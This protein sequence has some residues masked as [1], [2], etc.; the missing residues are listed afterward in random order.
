MCAAA[1]CRESLSLKCQR[2]GLRSTTAS[3]ILKSCPRSVS[4]NIFR[5]RMTSRKN[6]ELF[7][8]LIL[9]PVYF[10]L[11]TYRSFHG[12]FGNDDIYTLAW[13][14]LQSP[15]FFLKDTLNFE[16]LNTE[17]LYRPFGALA[18]NILYGIFGLNFFAFHL[19][20]NGIHLFNVFCLYRLIQKLV[21]GRYCALLGAFIFSFHIANLHIYWFVYLGDL[22]CASLLLL[23]L[24]LYI[25]S[26]GTFNLKYFLAFCFFIFALRSK[27]IAF[28]F[29]L[30]LT[31]YEILVRRKISEWKTSLKQVAIT[32]WPFYAI[33]ILAIFMKLS[34]YLHVER[35]HPYAITLSLNSI[36][37]SLHFYLG[38][39]LTFQN[40]SLITAAV[41]LFM[42]A[43]LPFIFRSTILAFAFWFILISLIPVLPLAAHRTDYYLYIPLIGISLYI[44][45]L[46]HCLQNTITKV[47]P[48]AVFYFHFLTFALCIVYSVTNLK[49]KA[50]NEEYLLNLTRKNR[51]F[52]QLLQPLKPNSKSIFLFDNP[53]ANFD[54]I[55]LFYVTYLL[56]HGL[57]I[58]TKSVAECDQSN[59]N[60]A[61]PDVYCVSFKNRKI[62]HK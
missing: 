2:P 44:A 7:L 4:C 56:Y 58:E 43:I 36:M 41:L 26:A 53:A 49:Q 33:A 47:R 48:K 13:T 38:T 8:L 50:R 61:G 31:M 22:L 6:T 16:T 10:F 29:P 45:E 5:R 39:A 32:N 40:F 9:I 55:G 30:I 35:E 11:M 51:E 46:F 18:F 15:M 34:A 3:A 60:S 54:D 37:E 27:E 52:I 28:T 23:S 12:Y 62:F 21:P 1:A 25:E 17:A 57:D 42:A 19:I 24:S 20:A 14:H 59:I